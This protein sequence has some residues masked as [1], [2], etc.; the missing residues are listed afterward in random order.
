MSVYVYVCER[1]SM[2]E[3]PCVCVF[4]QTREN[5][6]FVFLSLAYFASCTDFWFSSFPTNIMTALWLCKSCCL[7]MTCF[8]LFLCPFHWVAELKLPWMRLRKLFQQQFNARR[9]VSWFFLTSSLPRLECCLLSP[10]SFSRRKESTLELPWQGS[11]S[12]QQ[13]VP[14]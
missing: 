13:P 6:S 11:L 9:W 10:S 1:E 5:V 3:R 2:W 7:H 4:L 8:C 12:F 14:D